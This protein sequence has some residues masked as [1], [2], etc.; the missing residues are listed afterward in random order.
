MS[1]WV[2]RLAA[3]GLSLLAAAPAGACFGARLRVGVPAEAPAALASYA[4]GYYVE[5]KTG[6]APEFVPVA[7]P[8][9]ALTQ[10]RVDLVLVPE[11]AAAPPGAQVRAAGEAPGLGRAQLW[12]RAEVLDDLR[13]FT[14]DRALGRFPGLLA[15]P[16]Y[17]RAA[18]S[19]DPPRKAARR[20]VLDGP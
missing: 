18:Q 7:A 6:I 19:Q 10:G 9:E 16:A 4:A 20:A 15:S 12:L 2:A 13:F 3:A 17:A 1:A 8:A 5:E 11:G 14:L